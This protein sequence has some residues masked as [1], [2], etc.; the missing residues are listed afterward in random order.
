ML[1]IKINLHTY[2]YV[3]VCLDGYDDDDDVKW[4]CF[5]EERG[6]KIYFNKGAFPQD[7]KSDTLT[8]PQGKLLHM[9]MCAN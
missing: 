9:C 1:N 4:G 3:K 8:S 7:P 6:L 5:L 2:T